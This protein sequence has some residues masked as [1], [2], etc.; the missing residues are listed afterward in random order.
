MYLQAYPESV[1]NDSKVETPPK[2]TVV[3]SNS[4]NSLNNVNLADSILPEHNEIS[5]TEKQSEE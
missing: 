1:P 4:E 3:K 2:L 5:E